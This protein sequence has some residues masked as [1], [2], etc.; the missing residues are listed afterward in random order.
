[1]T[2]IDGGSIDIDSGAI[3]KCITLKV[4]LRHK[5]VMSVRCRLA[6]MIVAVADRIA[7]FR[8]ELV[9]AEPPSTRH[10]VRVEKVG[11]DMR[12]VVG[13][14]GVRLERRDAEHIGDLLSTRWP[15]GVAKVRADDPRPVGEASID[16]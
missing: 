4:R 3:L 9:T 10:D 12:L 13:D 15:G 14:R 5:R 6:A 8:L 7:P 1:M 11:T 16:G 2:A